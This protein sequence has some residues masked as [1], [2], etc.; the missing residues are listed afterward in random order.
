MTI[1]L[2][3][4]VLFLAVAIAGLAIGLAN[5]YSQVQALRDDR[6]RCDHRPAVVRP[7]TGSTGSLGATAPPPLPFIHPPRSRTGSLGA[8]K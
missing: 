8:V 5:L 7:N 4:V 1:K 3:T 6:C 2:E